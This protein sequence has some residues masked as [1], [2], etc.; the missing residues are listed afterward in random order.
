MGKTV[1]Y[2]AGTSHFS[3][4]RANKHH[5]DALYKPDASHIN[6]HISTKHPEIDKIHS[7]KV[8][9]IE[10]MH[11]HKSALAREVH[12]AELINNCPFDLLNLK[13]EY[14]SCIMPKIMVENFDQVRGY[15]EEEENNKNT[16]K[17][18]ILMYWS[19]CLY[20]KLHKKI[21]KIQEKRRRF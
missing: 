20:Q 17:K 18:L 6:Y 19:M 14:N 7:M 21:M 2:T 12:E 4:E 16:K 10:V 8:F 9:K 15:I 11:R 1:Q 13:E 5:E 3:F